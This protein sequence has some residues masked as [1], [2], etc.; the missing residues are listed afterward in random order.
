MPRL[1]LDRVD[2]QRSQHAFGVSSSTLRSLVLASG[3]ITTASA[4]INLHLWCALKG[5]SST[6]ASSRAS[7]PAASPPP[8]SGAA[9]STCLPSRLPVL[10]TF[11]E[12]VSRADPSDLGT[13]QKNHAAGPTACFSSEQKLGVQAIAVLPKNEKEWPVYWR[14]S[15]FGSLWR[16]WS[17]CKI[18]TLISAIDEMNAANPP[19]RRQVFATTTIKNDLATLTSAQAAD[20]YFVASIRRVNVKSLVWTLVLQPLLPVWVRKG[21]ASWLGLHNCTQEFLVIINHTS[22]W[23]EHLDDDDAVRRRANRCRCSS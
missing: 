17:T 21:D 12:H 20:C 1:Y 11:H 8:K 5:A 16:L 13:S 9:Y 4:S 6:S 15:S 3:S 7:R 19:G 10:A 18:R 23:V 14:S 22:D 2:V